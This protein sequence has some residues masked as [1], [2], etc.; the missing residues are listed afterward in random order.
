MADQKLTDLPA[1]DAFADDD[2]LYVVDVTDGA[3]KRGN[4]SQLQSKVVASIQATL[5]LATSALQPGDVGT[6]AAQNV[7]AFATAAQGAL[8]DTATQPAD[9]AAIGA[10][11]AVSSG[12]ALA[13]T[14]NE[15]RLHVT[16]A[17]TLT[18]PLQATVAWLAGTVVALLAISDQVTVTAAEGATLNGVDGASLVIDGPYASA[19]LERL[20]ENAW[21][22]TGALA[23]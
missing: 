3:S 18:I 17:V 16:G 14:D 9:L 5:D 11:V 20:S 10:I 22:L 15:K 23:A 13:L 6:A 8:A 4:V 2:R 1:I 7:E 19:V 12:R 21:A